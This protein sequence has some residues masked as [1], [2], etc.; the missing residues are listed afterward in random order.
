MC[1]RR[2]WRK[3]KRRVF[4]VDWHGMTVRVSVPYGIRITENE[5]EKQVCTYLDMCH[6]YGLPIDYSKPLQW[7]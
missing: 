3:P 2:L 1:M 4:A 7:Q 6:D 5:L